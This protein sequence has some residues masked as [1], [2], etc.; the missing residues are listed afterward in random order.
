MLEHAIYSVISPEGAASILWHD[1]TKARD[2]AT[3]MK[4][5]AQDL[6]QLGIIDGII[7]EPIGGAHRDPDTAIRR[8]SE[9][10]ELA[11][12]DFDSVEGSDIRK[13]RQDKFLAIGKSLSLSR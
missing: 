10:L 13:Q 9:A 12:L 1:S 3:G 5:T 6:L 11:L 7:S 4:I 8:V 2:A